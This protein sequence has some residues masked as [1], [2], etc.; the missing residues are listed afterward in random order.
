MQKAKRIR[1]RRTLDVVANDGGHDDDDDVDVDVAQSPLLPLKTSPSA[2]ATSDLAPSFW[3]LILHSFFLCEI[4]R[5][6]LIHF[7]I[8]NRDGVRHETCI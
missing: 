3:G 4:R 8:R 6:F 1:T 5:F 7:R 2:V